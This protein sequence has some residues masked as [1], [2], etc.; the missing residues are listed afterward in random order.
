MM[1]TCDYCHSPGQPYEYKGI[2]FDGLVPYHGDRICS[3]CCDRAHRDYLA[4]LGEL[5]PVYVFQ[6]RHREHK[7]LPSH[8]RPAGTETRPR[9]TPDAPPPPVKVTPHTIRDHPDCQACIRPDLLPGW[10]TAQRQKADDL[11]AKAR[12]Y[13]QAGKDAG[14]RAVA[15]L[16]DHRARIAALR[17]QTELLG[18]ANGIMTEVHM[19]R[20]RVNQVESAH[21]PLPGPQGET[22]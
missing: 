7:P 22:P 14:T 6:G 18:A 1:S 2:Q 20:G 13:R 19:I 3:R 4:E 9:P 21:P 16:H 11:V 5:V 8:L 15:L 12:E 17:E 10:L